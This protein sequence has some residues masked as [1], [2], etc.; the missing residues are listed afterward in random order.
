MNPSSML[1][2]GKRLAPVGANR[3]PARREGV[4]GLNGYWRD[5]GRQDG[6]DGVDPG[7]FQPMAS[8][9][10]IVV[11]LG[12]SREKQRQSERQRDSQG[13]CE[14][15]PPARIDRNLLFTLPGQG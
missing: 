13:P 4:V 10:E 2:A 11:R 3:R 6:A 14:V 5:S 15:F 8:K 7:T 12:L 9:L 1:G